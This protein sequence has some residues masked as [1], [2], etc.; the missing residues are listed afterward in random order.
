M[1][2]EDQNL[3]RE[4]IVVLPTVRP[5][6]PVDADAFYYRF[7]KIHS[8]IVHKTHLV[9]ELDDS[10]LAR[11]RELFIDTEWLQPPHR[12]ALDDRSGAKPAVLVTHRFWIRYMSAD[13]GVVGE[14]LRINNI[15]YVVTGVLALADFYGENLGAAREDDLLGAALVA[16]RTLIAYFLNKEI[17]EITHEQ[18][19]AS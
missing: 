14:V 17:Q 5:Y 4:E 16:I 8:T 1:E 11:I 13:P 6:D 10:R 12:E 7:R 18:R 2:F 9:V 3:E 19:A 15:L